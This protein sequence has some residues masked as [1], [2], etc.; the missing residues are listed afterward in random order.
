MAALSKEP[1]EDFLRLKRRFGDFLEDY[2]PG[3]EDR[4]AERLGQLLRAPDAGRQYGGRRL[5]IDVQDLQQFDDK[6][7]QELVRNPAEAIR[8]CVDAVKDAAK[9]LHDGQYADKFAAEIEVRPQRA[10]AHESAGPI[11]RN[12]AGR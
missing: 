10:G 12:E 2:E 3:R 1:S 11:V 9:A 4:Y 7:H 6:L 5:V 8:P